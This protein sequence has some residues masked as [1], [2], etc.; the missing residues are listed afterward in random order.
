MLFFP[1]C[2]LSRKE[3]DPKSSAFSASLRWTVTFFKSDHPFWANPLDNRFIRCE[4]YGLFGIIPEV[5]D[6]LESWDNLNEGAGFIQVRARTRIHVFGNVTSQK[7][8]VTASGF[9]LEREWR[10][11]VSVCHSHESG[12]PETARNIWFTPTYWELTGFIENLPIS[13]LNPL[14]ITLFWKISRKQ[15]K[16]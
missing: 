8:R 7:V 13:F 12:N 6:L 2:P 1:F 16:I 15:K 11:A 3:K 4:I 10:R 14:F 5:F 9:P